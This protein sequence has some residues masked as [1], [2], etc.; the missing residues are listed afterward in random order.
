MLFVQWRI[1]Q[2]M[3]RSSLSSGG[4]YTKCKTLLRFEGGRP[5]SGLSQR[6]ILIHTQLPIHT[7]RE[8][9]LS[10]RNVHTDGSKLASKIDIPTSHVK[11]AVPPVEDTPHEARIQTALLFRYRKCATRAR[12]RKAQKIAQQA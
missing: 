6:P 4:L 2:M 5:Q 11:L 7:I 12:V 3:L 1:W 8:F 9:H 10:G